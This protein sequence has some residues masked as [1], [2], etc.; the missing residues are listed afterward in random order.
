MN[1]KSDDDKPTSANH[2]SEKERSEERKKW[3][4]G[5]KT[6]RIVIDETK[7]CSVDRQ[8]LPHDAEFKGYVEV[9]VQD[10]VIQPHNILFRKENTILHR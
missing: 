8:T 10:I 2:S 1:I 7:V 5:T 4:K 3:K 9:T 6:H